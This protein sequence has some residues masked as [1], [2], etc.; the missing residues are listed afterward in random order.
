M[1]PPPSEAGAPAGRPLVESATA[2]GRYV[3]V[4]TYRDGP[5]SPLRAS[6]LFRTAEEAS[7][8]A[9]LLAAAVWSPR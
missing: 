7:E 9:R 1:I 5:Q 2:S 3:N 4:T 8:C 6:L